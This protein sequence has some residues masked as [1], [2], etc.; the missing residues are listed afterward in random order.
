MMYRSLSSSQSWLLLWLGSRPFRGSH[1]AC[2]PV[3]ISGQ[4]RGLEFQECMHELV[5]ECY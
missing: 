2:I 1:F 3:V 4:E 5:R